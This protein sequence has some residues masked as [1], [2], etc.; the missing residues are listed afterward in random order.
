MLLPCEDCILVLDDL[1]ARKVAK[2]MG[3]PFTGTLGI[4]ASAKQ[5]GIIPLARPLFEQIS[6][7]DFRISEKFMEAIL[8]ELG[9]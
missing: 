6:N 4:I 1:R 3:I 8:A 5:R 2:A 9:E 7:T